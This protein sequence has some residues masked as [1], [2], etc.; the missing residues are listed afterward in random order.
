MKKVLFW[1]L[2]VII[3][4]VAA[5]VGYGYYT[6]THRVEGAYFDS[7]GVKIHYTDEGEGEPVVLIHGF[8]VN[9]DLNWRWEGIIDAL[10]KDFRVVAMDLRGHGL[11][12][13]P[14][15]AEQYGEEMA[16]DVVRLMDHL[17]IE[18]AHIVGYSLGAFISL[19]LATMHPER[20]LTAC[21]L[22]AGW[23]KLEE[24]RVFPA[25]EALSRTLDS[26]HGIEPPSGKF[27]EG[28]ARV[29]FL[30]TAMVR[31]MTG[32][33][34][35]HQALAA[36]LRSARDLA[37]TEDAVRGIPVP[38]CSIVGTR[39][40]LKVGVENMQGVVPDLKV[41]LVENADHL[42][43]PMRPEF[44]D[45]LRAFLQAHRQGNDAEESTQ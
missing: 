17:S 1:G 6:L 16:K 28:R 31:V 39:D 35:D 3:A 38:V 9:S 36:V 40:P 5:G 10:A 29:G 25:L 27:G 18:K 14:H 21:P 12:G 20:M 45:A 2:V 30:Q 32:F 24:S 26:G 4:V 34:N 19:K 11:S 37:V 42:R 41:V 7:D 44:L 15:D 43:T 8:A 23:E 22:G 33:F 13:K